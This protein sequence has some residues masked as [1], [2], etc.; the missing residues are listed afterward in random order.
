M[1]SKEDAVWII[2]EVS[3]KKGAAVFISL[4]EQQPE[5]GDIEMVLSVSRKFSQSVKRFHLESAAYSRVFRCRERSLVK[6]R[7]RGNSQ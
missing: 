5:S 4:S 1:R 3:Y 6:S 7:S 2:E